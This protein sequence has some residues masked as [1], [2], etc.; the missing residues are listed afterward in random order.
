MLFLE[1]NIGRTRSAAAALAQY[2]T[3]AADEQRAEEQP[4]AATSSSQSSSS[5]PQQ[6]VRWQW[7]WWWWWWWQYSGRQQQQWQYKNQYTAD[8]DCRLCVRWH[9]GGVGHRHEP[10][11][12]V[13]HPT[14]P[15]HPQP[16][17]SLG[18]SYS[19]YATLPIYAF[20]THTHTRI[21]TMHSIS[22]INIL[23]FYFCTIY[24]LGQYNSDMLFL[25][26]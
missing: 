19:L 2:E 25:L 7:Q 20:T 22:I 12:T 4:A 9:G 21:H 6:W 10:L 26:V 8:M 11:H 16:H 17:R 24:P 3:A 5:S 14:P 18:S 23:S 1:A 15:H 13:S